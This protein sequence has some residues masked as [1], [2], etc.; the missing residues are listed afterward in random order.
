[1]RPARFIQNQPICVKPSYHT[2]R[3]HPATSRIGPVRHTQATVSWD[4]LVRLEGCHCPWAH[5]QTICFS[6]WQHFTACCGVCWGFV[7]GNERAIKHSHLPVLLCA[8]HTMIFHG[9]HALSVCGILS[10]LYATITCTISVIIRH[11]MTDT[12]SDTIYRILYGYLYGYYLHSLSLMKH[13]NSK[14][15]DPT[16][17]MAKNTR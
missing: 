12:K 11:I 15:S 1:M 5:S 10:W 3:I 17:D 4:G 16:K 7:S 2:A 9:K 14:M 8:T 13:T 6:H